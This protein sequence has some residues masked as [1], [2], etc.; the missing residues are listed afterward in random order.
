MRFRFLPAVLAL[1]TLPLL[2]ATAP[3]GAAP[4]SK[5]TPGQGAVQQ[6]RK[7]VSSVAERY[8][9]LKG[10]VLEGYSESRFSST[11]REK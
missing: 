1:A 9:T 6:A 4:P 7:A 2:L 10:Y 8:R 5:S 3:P 11:Q